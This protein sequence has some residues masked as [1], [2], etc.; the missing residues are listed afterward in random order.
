MPAFW[1][2]WFCD[3]AIE[4]P[5][6]GS[7]T[8]AE[9]VSLCVWARLSYLCMFKDHSTS[10]TTERVQAHRIFNL[11]NHKFS[12][13]T[14]ARK[15]TCTVSACHGMQFWN[16]KLALLNKGGGTF[17]PAAV[18]CYKIDLWVITLPCNPKVLSCTKPGTEASVE[19]KPSILQTKG[20]PLNFQYGC[21]DQWSSR[22]HSA[23]ATNQRALL[24]RGMNVHV[25]TG[26]CLR[27]KCWWC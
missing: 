24:N 2:H 8:P 15:K 13:L 27:R 6:G 9:H 17:Q 21:K 23:E 1:F 20:T 5:Q 12:P 4:R 26:V 16:I 19:T 10:K 18:K 14:H 22:L 7:G 25:I 11:S 3:K